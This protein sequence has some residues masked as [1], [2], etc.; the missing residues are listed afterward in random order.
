MSFAGEPIAIVGTGCRFPGDSNTPSLLWR[1]LREPRD[2]L[3]PLAERFNAEGWYHDDGKYHGHCNIKQSYQLAGK[4]TCRYFDAQFFNINAIEASTLD[5]QVRLLLET[6]Y[7]ALEAAGIPIET[8]QGSDTAV[9]TGMMTNSYKTA[10]E[11]DGDS[12]GTYHSTGISR[13]MMSNR[14]SYFFNWHGPSMTIDTAC[15]SSMVAVHQAVMQLRTGQ[16]RVAVA[17]GSNLFLDSADHVSMSKLEMLSPESR[18]RMWDKDANGYA[19]GE[20][21]AAVVLKT[22]SAAEAAGDH[23]E[24]L[25]RETATNQD[26][27]TPGITMPSVAAQTQ[28]IRDCYAR[29]GLDLADPAQRPQYFEAHGTGT[30]AGDP[31]EAKAIH[32]AFFPHDN[33]SVPSELAPLL[34]GSIKTVIGHSESVAGLAGL[35]KT[36]LALQNAIVPPNL[37]FREINPK[38]APFYGNLRVPTSAVP[39]PVVRDGSPRRASINSFGFGGANAHA[40]LES[41]T[42][43][44]QIVGKRDA[45]FIPF[46]FS[47]ASEASLFANLAAV[48]DHLQVNRTNMNL[49]D[50]AMTLHSRK[51][52]LPFGTAVA[53]STVPQLCDKLNEICQKRGNNTE[54]HVGTQTSARQSSDR[55]RKAKVLGIFTGQGAQS[56]RMGAA[57]IEQSA[58]CERIIDKLEAR[59]AALPSEDRPSWSL[60][61]ELLRDSTATVNQA[62]L[63]QPLCTALQILQVDLLRVAGVEFSAVVGHSAGEVGAAYYAGMISAEDA[64]CI[65][66]YRG[67]YADLAARSGGQRG[68]MLAVGT[69]FVEAQELCNE[70]E[71][72]NKVFVAAINSS[73]S[74]TLS[75]DEEAIN[76]IRM[77]LEDKGKFVRRLKVDMAYHSPYMAPCSRI[78]LRALNRLGIRPRK[79]NNTTSWFSS[80]DEGKLM[81]MDE[82]FKLQ[83]TYWNENMMK[84]VMF[85]QAVQGAWK[86]RGPF[87]LAIELG[88]HPAL[89]GPALQTLR[90]CSLP[91]VPYT[92]VHARGQNAV[93]SFAN[94]LGYIWN[95][96]G[97]INL[98][99]YDMFVSG[100]ISYGLVTGLPSYAWNHEKEYWHESRYTKAI[101]TR[102]EPVNELLGHLSPDSTDQ[103]MRWRNILYPKELSWLNDHALQNQPVFPASGYVV[104]AVEAAASMTRARGLSASLIEVLD[105]DISKALAF[106]SDDSRIETI[107]SLTDIRQ[108]GENI[109][110]LFKFNATPTFGGTTLTLLASASIRVRLGHGDEAALPPRGPRMIGLSKVDSVDFYESLSRLDCQYTGPFRALSGLE[111]K[112]GSATGYINNE[113]S[114]LLI[115]PAVLDAAFQ[116]LFLAH[117]AP[118][119]GGIWSIQVPKTIRA[120]RVD[121]LLCAASA[122]RGIPIAFDCMQQVGAPTLEGDIELFPGTDGIQHTMVQVETLRC[123]PLSRP[124][125]GDDKEMYS[126]ITWDVA[127]PNAEQVVYDGKP[128]KEQEELARLLERMAVFF[129]RRLDV[130]VPKDHPAR[131][132]DTYRNFFSFASYTL[133]RA[134]ERKLP[135]WSVKWEHDSSDD[136]AAAY[137]PYL[138]VVDVKLLKAIGDNVVNI[139]TGRTPA[140]EVAMED[141]ML[142]QIYQQG[143]G[144]REY[145]KFA[146]RLVGQ[147]AHRYPQMNILEVGAGTGA[148]TKEIFHE[149]GHNFSSYTYTDISSGFFA[150]AE[151]TFTSRCHKMLYKVLD[152]GKDIKQQGYNEHSYDLVVAFAVLHA[153][154]SIQD[155]L[156]NVRR[157]L[158]PGG[159]LVVLELDIADLTRVGAIFGALPGWWLGAGEGRTLSPCVDM[160]EWDR[161]LRTTGFSGCDTITPARDIPVMPLRAFVSQAVN[162]HVQFLRDP[163]SQPESLFQDNSTMAAQ[164]LILLGGDGPQTSVL[165]PQLKKD[166]RRPWRQNIRT[167]RSLTDVASLTITSDTTVLSLL[168]V[169]T[170]VFENLNESNWEALKFLLQK[171]GTVLWV[172]SGRRVNKPYANMMVGLLRSARKEIPTLEIQCFDADDDKLLDAR[173][174][175]ETLLRLKAATMWKRQED[176]DSPLT[177]VEPELVRGRNTA[178]LIPRLVASQE[179]NDRY[180]S[181]RR[182]IFAPVPAYGPETNLGIVRPDQQDTYLQEVPGPEGGNGSV[183]R[184]THSLRS[185]VRVSA[186]GYMHLVLGRRCDSDDQV[187]ALTSQHTLKSAPRVGLTISA[188]VPPGSESSFV[189]LLA[190]H[191]LASLFFEGLS[192]G[193]TAIIH[194]PEEQFSSILADE[195]GRH[196]VKAVFT[197]TSTTVAG[198]GWVTIHPMSPDRTIRALIPPNTAA[199]FD[200]G[201]EN[202]PGSAGSRLRAQLPSHCR[203]HSLDTAFSASSTWEPQGKQIPSIRARLE[204]CISR[205]LARLA[206][207]CGPTATVSLD[208]LAQLSGGVPHAVVDWSL[209]P[210]GLSVRVRPASSTIQFSESRT[211]WLAG[212]N[213]GLSVLLCE[214]M[215]RH[216]AKYFVISSRT[217]S[218]DETWIKNMEAAGAVVKAFSCDIT[219]EL[220]VSDLYREIQST[221]PPVAGVCQGESFGEIVPEDIPIYDMPLEALLKVTRPK[222]EGSLHLDQ[223]FQPQDSDLEFFIF[224]SSVGSVTGQPG[225]GNYAAA[226]LF[227]T[228]LAE[229]RRRRGQAAS[230]M[231]IGPVLGAGYTTQQPLDSGSKFITTEKSISPISDSDLFQHFAEAIIA[232]RFVSQTGTFEVATDLARFESVQ[233][234]GPLLSHYFTQNQAEKAADEPVVKAKVS[235]TSELAAARGRAQVTRIIREAFLLNLSSQLQIEYPKLEKAEPKELRL[236]ELGMDSLI[237]VE[238]RKWLLKNFQVNISV[239]RILSGAPVADL[240]DTVTE[241]IPRQLVPMFDEGPDHQ[242]NER[243]QPV[244]REVEQPS[245]QIRHEEN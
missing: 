46:V 177:T 199:L 161:L 240:I 5:P 3:E 226:D 21:V 42:G 48:R 47:A 109:E 54:Q 144:F 131:F 12:I 203:Y 207:P 227:M 182:P 146:A 63:S 156:G 200:L 202:A 27:R 117:F 149:I 195:A 2:L 135:L 136:L 188:S 127:T 196:G 171:A 198:P 95:H 37:L 168:E 120:I 31:A 89:R 197:T 214:W 206:S 4:G 225:Q 233:E 104:A 157:L 159:F 180:N 128:T 57:L 36:S 38:V 139:V 220:A 85:M 65:A 73:A 53:A 67:R 18:S 219:D 130:E 124:T 216:G 43:K 86:S 7:E 137:A 224:F 32:T 56:V 163:L 8:L 83:A 231:H 147:I 70:P 218:V 193:A 79:A 34:V 205:T 167:A 141:E 223:L 165:I 126:K 51:S 229:R 151:Q 111:R 221:L 107:N 122:K 245:R 6:V 33:G 69:S 152:I 118:N 194:E 80:V 24:C 92:G 222:V 60:K 238:I 181:S 155:T 212:L 19:R 129:L 204:G 192:E 17:A 108:R 99:S 39:W 237:A 215:V 11:R 178:L 164:E 101:R 125:A 190:Y 115:H 82:S 153:T 72:Q 50:L 172:S 179:M 138:H 77:I 45:C 173:E 61:Q 41:Y 110:A 116:S 106:D 211:Y 186:F 140:I 102:S 191:L 13:A 158:K 68:A 209:P 166:L 201:A 154:P 1:L 230:V 174:L 100:H 235:L 97:T 16:S 10:M 176:Q 52:R 175:A 239:L 26:G 22:L 228:A 49:R 236:D 184:V 44:K 20:G 84:P 30:P 66:Y 74:V 94:A 90:E 217:P 121:P 9:Y 150:N 242:A 58:S 28:L 123:T 55:G 208:T 187:V 112:L 232:G 78:Y 103:D 96:L 25:I 243:D 183:V 234:A 210:L 35:I 81:S 241:E 162:S 143:L 14:I 142:S 169:D 87:D 189:A 133:S 59:L 64:I 134:K 114:R 244:Q 29:A 23:I 62:A 91:I 160:A 75:G 148:A 40:V 76:K 145:T 213:G 71:F 170:P 132:E 93:E 88:P 15:S 119:S 98:S 105:L 113:R 185:A